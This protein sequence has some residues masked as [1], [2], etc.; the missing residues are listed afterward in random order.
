M[1]TAVALSARLLLA[2]LNTSLTV[3]GS[4]NNSLVHDC[5]L[6]PSPFHGRDPTAWRQ[7]RRK[8][9]LPL[10]SFYTP[11][12]NLTYIQ[13]FGLYGSML[14]LVCLLAFRRVVVW[15]SAIGSASLRALNTRLDSSLKILNF[16]G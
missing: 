1:L 9:R 8:E 15:C 12:R 4:E 11:P 2:M 7:D 3:F 5:V 13:R 6:L 16:P 14:P 10:P